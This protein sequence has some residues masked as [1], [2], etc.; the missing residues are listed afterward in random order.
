M[1]IT[2]PFSLFVSISLL[3]L[4]LFALHFPPPFLSVSSLSLSI[5]QVLRK[6]DGDKVTVV[7]AGVT[8]HEALAA[9]KTLQAEGINIRVVDAFCL[10]VSRAVC[11]IGFQRCKDRNSILCL[12]SCTC[13]PLRQIVNLV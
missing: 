3:L 6:S 7:G 4:S 5:A 11:Q 13:C 8:L 9:H 1:K 12:R 10:K 2:S